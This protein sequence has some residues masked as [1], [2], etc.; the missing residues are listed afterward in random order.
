MHGKE[1]R[2]VIEADNQLAGSHPAERAG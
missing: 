2:V 1:E